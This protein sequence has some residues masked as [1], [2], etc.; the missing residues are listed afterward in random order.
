MKSLVFL[1]LF[2]SIRCD[3]LE[4]SNS[5]LINQCFIRDINQINFE[6]S[7][8]YSHCLQCTIQT[9][10]E[11]DDIQ[12]IHDQNCSSI[13]LQ[14]VQIFFDNI[15]LFEE[16]FPFHQQ[17]IYDLF[18]KTNGINQNTLHIIIKNNS[19]TQIESVYIEQRFDANFQSYRVL[20][21][22][23][24]LQQMPI[25]INRNLTALIRLPMKIILN[26]QDDK[27]V[28]RQTIYIIYNQ[29]I[30][31]ETTDDFCSL[32]TT[33]STT[34]IE[35]LPLTQDKSK[36]IILII[37]FLTVIL[38]AIALTISVCI[39]RRCKR[40]YRRLS[41]KADTPSELS[42][43]PATPK[44]KRKARGLRALQLIDDEV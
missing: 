10:I 24:Y 29:N 2:S 13:H 38:S 12:L 3:C 4:F 14:C 39:Y 37:I 41:T 32:S 17:L 40:I 36:D 19:L 8:F 28:K 18:D 42:V 31:R 25:E 5:S 34:T 33:I 9:S 27:H 21:F 20:F 7:H 43:S 15:E 35:M 6:I 16:F 1:L 22:E 11:S 44:I 26:C 30:S 23:L